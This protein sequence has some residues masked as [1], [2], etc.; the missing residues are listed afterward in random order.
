M[1]NLWLNA[2][3][4]LKHQTTHLQTMLE[5]HKIVGQLPNMVV[6]LDKIVVHSALYHEHLE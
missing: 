2:P 6:H 3:P 5:Y 4:P 1:E